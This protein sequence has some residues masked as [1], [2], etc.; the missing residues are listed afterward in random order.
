MSSPDPRLFSARNRRLILL[1]ITGH[2]LWS[3]LVVSLH[4]AG[5][6]V[7]K[8]G[9]WWDFGFIA[10]QLFAAAQLLLPALLLEPAERQRGF[11]LFWGTALAVLTWSFSQL[12][13]VD[14]WQPLLNAGKAGFLLLT[15]TLIGTV[16]A[17]YV[18]R[19][20]EIIPICLAMTIA[21]FSSWLLGP[22]AEFSR[23]IQTYYT[24]PTGPKPLIDMVLVKFAFPDSARLLPVFGISDWIMVV[25][26]I[27]VAN[28]YRK[29]DNLLGVAGSTI[30]RQKRLRCYVP[31][32]VVALCGALVWAQSGHLFIPALPLIAGVTLLWHTLG[33]LLSWRQAAR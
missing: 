11:Y 9:P 7:T 6:L 24:A 3:G 4:Y 33:A 17:Q 32:P 12:P 15:A 27:S 23:Q 31:I 2:L 13:A 25:F 18:K 10:V 22:T 8:S 20:W 1:L 29:N 21:D 26:F 28:R 14:D 5:M 30:A 19:L 16:L